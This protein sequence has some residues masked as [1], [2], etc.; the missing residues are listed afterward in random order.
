MRT[1]SVINQ[2]AELVISVITSINEQT[3]QRRVGKLLIY[4]QKSPLFTYLFLRSQ[5]RVEEADKDHHM[6]KLLRCLPHWSA[7]LCCTSVCVIWGCTDGVWEK[8][9]WVYLRFC[10]FLLVN[11]FPSDDVESSDTLRLKILSFQLQINTLKSQN[12]QV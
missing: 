3:Q 12:I 11:L 5:W 1:V 8:V 4:W 9:S 10:F 2:N 7:V 6:E